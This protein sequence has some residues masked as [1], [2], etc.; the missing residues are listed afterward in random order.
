MRH[1]SGIAAVITLMAILAASPAALRS[2][3]KIEVTEATEGLYFLT[4]V[5]CNVAFLVTVEGVLVV[6]SGV[7]AAH[8]DS[9]VAAIR[10]ITDAPIKYLVFT[11]YHFDHVVGACR[12]PDETT[13]ISHADLPANQQAFN[14]PRLKDMIEKSYPERIGAE[15][16]KL[17]S[18]S[19][20]GSEA[21]GETADALENLRKQFE[22][23]QEIRLVYPDS[24]FDDEM[25][26]ELGGQKIRLYHPGP[27]HTSG[28]IIVHFVD[29]GAVH[30]GDMLFYM[31]HP[32]IDWKAGSNTANWVKTLEAVAQWDIDV[33]MPGH[34]RLTDR[35]GLTWKAQYLRDLRAEVGAAV[36]KGMS[37]EEA[38]AAVRMEKYAGLEWTYMLDAGIAA[39]YKELTGEER[40]L[41][42]F[43][44]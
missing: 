33:V 42:V 15:Q 2:Q 3:E 8:G 16:A 17:D 40:A 21:S 14:E 18:L 44:E 34:G 35:S 38:G 36:E 28:N 1:L 7:A 25:I 11:H 32:Y 26:I 6:D 43:R 41:P 39:V 12:F 30:M 37:L 22:A 10:E 29:L 5:V 31:R 23:A 20:S 27:A 24:T 9:I 4:G 19:A 13:I